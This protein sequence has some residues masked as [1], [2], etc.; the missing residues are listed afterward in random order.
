[1]SDKEHIRK[2]L[3]VA[4]DFVEQVLKN[5]ELLK[6]IPDGAEVRF[7]NDET[8]KTEKIKKL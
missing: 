2:D 5:P 7:L 6:Q 4:F 3:I 1:M 8:P